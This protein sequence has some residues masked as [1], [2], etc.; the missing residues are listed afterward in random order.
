MHG[1]NVYVR[2]KSIKKWLLLRRA[3][4]E[5]DTLTDGCSIISVRVQ[6]KYVRNGAK[7]VSKEFQKLLPNRFGVIRSAF[8][9]CRQF[10]YVYQLGFRPVPL[11]CSRYFLRVKK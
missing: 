5:T 4:F 2:V 6:I 3:R 11:L 10:R 9:R 8:S 7:D 1:V